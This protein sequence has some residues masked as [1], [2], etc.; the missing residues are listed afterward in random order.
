MKKKFLF[1][2]M[3]LA[4]FVG[5]A[6]AEGEFA[7][8]IENDYVFYFRP[9]SATEVAIIHPSEYDPNLGP[10]VGQFQWDFP[11]EVTHDGVTYTIT[12]IASGA[13]RDATVYGGN[14]YTNMLWLPSSLTT[15]EDDAFDNWTSNMVGVYGDVDSKAFRNNKINRIQYID[16]RYP[17]S[18]TEDNTAGTYSGQAQGGDLVKTVEGKKILWAWGGDRRK[19]AWIRHISGPTLDR[20]Y[21]TTWTFN[22]DEIGDYALYGNSKLQTVT[23]QNA[24]KIGVEAMKNMTALTT[25]NLPAT[26]TEIAE[27]AFDGTTTIASIT[28]NAA[29]PPTGGV[30][31]DA[32]YA[33]IR[34]SGNITVP[35]DA[36]EAYQAD[37]NWYKFWSETPPAPAETRVHFAEAE[38]GEVTADNL[39]PA[40]GATVTLTVNPAAGYKLENINAE[41]VIDPG[42]AQAPHR[43]AGPGVGLN[44]E[45][46]TV[47]EGQTYTFVMPDAPYEVLVTPEFALADY[48]ITVAD[49]IENG[50]VVADK[51][52]ANYGETVTVTTTPAEGYELENLTYTVEGAEPVAIENGTFTMPAGNVTINATF[53]ATDYTITVAET[54]NGTVEAPATANYGET[55]TVT[56]TPAEGYELG[57][58]TYTIGEDEPVAI[59]NGQ[60]TMPAADVTINATFT[61]IDY[62]ITVADTEN[63]TVTA[64]ATANYGETVTLTVTPA[65]GY[66]LTELTYTVSEDE[67]VAI[68]NGQF[69]MPAAS[70]TINATFTAIDYTI[71]VAETAHGT[72][73]ADK[74]TANI[75]ET[76]T[77]TATPA[78]GYELTEL[79]YTAE[80]AEPVTIENGQFTMP[81]AN[82]TIN[83]TFTAIGYTITVA[84]TENGTVVADKEAANY[85]ETVTLTVTPAEGYE[86]TELTYTAG[87]DEPVDIENN[88]FTMPAANVT[89]NATFTAIDY[90][91]TVAETEN[92]SVTAPATANFGETV[93]LTVTPA[94]GYE[95]TE[96]TYTVGED[97]PV[98]IE[99]NQFV[100]PAANVTINATFNLIPVVLDG[101][102]FAN[103]TYATWYGNQ[104]LAVPEN[105]TAYVVTGIENDVTVIEEVNYLPAGVGVLL[106]STT[107]ADV[108]TTVPYTGETAE[109]AS[110]LQGY[111]EDTTIDNGYV[112]YNDGFVLTGN[113]TLA[114]HRCYLPKAQAPAGAPKRLRIGMN[115]EIVT[116]IDDVRTAT[117]G[118]VRYIDVNGRVSNT[119][120]QGINIVIDGDKTYKAIMN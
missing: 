68:E 50:T 59:E 109:V 93:T 84:E 43:I 21:T 13:F 82:V 12:T 11:T 80:G 45:L 29:T 4:G 91:I 41:A 36:L 108:V 57:T 15:I 120:F 48:T 62:T 89:I 17:F 32:V 19:H 88:Q 92:G 115:G 42:N 2:M 18:I 54:E 112:L 1:L 100:M 70:V 55:V 98:A 51:Q 33:R 79:T 24:T 87:E 106:Y 104:N 63:G 47:V 73:E 114:A 83:A 9:I 86:L 71:T 101:V 31:D 5:V 7:Y 69:T 75:G 94:E 97:E 28:C 77:V 58:L 95:L 76:V 85:G 78:A 23:I 103:N 16:G 72:V 3:L 25:L 26:L 39:N 56:T 49:G 46:T 118:S 38:N 113:G 64:P 99:N 35:A 117:D 52:T 110:M 105:V 81:A 116:A 30:F 111:L 53:K 20:S 14:Q 102:V 10:Y 107:P 60:F 44:V 34:E 22:Y 6:Q 37:P 27:G 90:T 119:P 65:E 8:A 40:D 74:A 96:L 66:E 61:A 67:P